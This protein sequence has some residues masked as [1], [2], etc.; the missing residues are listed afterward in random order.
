MTNSGI[1]VDKFNDYVTESTGA[2]LVTQTTPEITLFPNRGL[3]LGAGSWKKPDGS[4]SIRFSKA[5]VLISSHAL[6]SGHFRI[7]YFSVDDLSIDI[8]LKKFLWEYV[9]SMKN[10]TGERAPDDIVR[11]IL[12]ALGIAPD[13]ID[14]QH[15][16]IC[17]IQPDDS[18]ITLE[19]F[20]LQA[21]NVHPGTD[22]DFSLNTVVKG[23]A[24]LFESVIDLRC[25]AL[26]SEKKAS[27]AIEK[28]LFTPKHGIRFSEALSLDGGLEYDFR[29][30]GL[31]LSKL[32]FTGPELSFTASGNV[33]SMEKMALDPR[34]GEASLKLHLK[35]DPQRVA[36]ILN[37]PLPFANHEIFH[38][39]ELDTEIRWIQGNIQMKDIKGR[40]DTLSFSGNLEGSLR[41]FVVNGDIKLGKLNL[42]AYKGEKKTSAAEER[43]EEKNFTRWPKLQLNV[44][45]EEIAFNEFQLEQV[46][47]RLT[48]QS[49]TYECNP[50]TCT[51]AESPVTASLTVRLLPSSP[52]SALISANLS[53]PQ[54]KLDELSQILT[55]RSILTGTGSLNTSLS[56]NSSKG[57]PSLNGNGS[58]TSS[59]AKTAFSLLPEGIPL[60]DLITPISTFN[61]LFCSFNIKNGNL[62]VAK[63]AL[64]S[65]QLSL[66]GSGS[67]DLSGKK[68][69]A[70][71]TLRAG[72][73]VIPVSLNGELQAPSY[74]L[75]MKK[76]FQSKNTPYRKGIPLDLN[77]TKKIENLLKANP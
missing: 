61:R 32:H 74:A 46:H 35:G 42:A 53:A 21:S 1:I 76:F 4:L 23:T 66:S 5:T 3:E 30:T 17:F 12:H 8:R 58:L 29:S 59:Q 6:F 18:T 63:A 69:N 72:T 73:S 40:A 65:P 54:I 33:T 49:G 38:D 60:G 55:K 43:R 27:F 31:T 26:F 15:G 50:F 68:I 39:C 57:F 75:E 67:I 36:A 41:P 11:T 45:A 77:F 70:S 25:T 62:N 56:F 47:M 52:I 51:F 14:I 28:A 24:P 22:T 71:G 10:S 20:T 13:N 16:R 19:P 44:T 9:P 64:E 7:K 34:L 2:P 48:G 37:R